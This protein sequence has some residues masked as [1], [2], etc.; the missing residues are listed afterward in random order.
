VIVGAGIAGVS[1]A[2]HLAVRRG[3]QRVVVCDPRQPLSLT[4]DKSTECYRNWWPQPAMTALMNRSIDL[5][6]E[7]ECPLSSRG[8]VYFTADHLDTFEQRARSVARAGAG[9]LRTHGLLSQTPPC[10]AAREWHR[11]ESGADLVTDPD[12]ISRLWPAVARRV[13][14]ALHVRRAGWLD[15]QQLGARLLDEAR[16]AGVGLLRRAVIRIETDRHGITGVE[17]D[18]GERIETPRVVV[19]AGPH[20]NTVVGLLGESVPVQAELHLKVA[21]KDHLGVVPRS[22]PLL[23]WDDP[24]RLAWGD[25]E[26]EALADLDPGLLGVL[27]GGAHLRP[28]GG[29]DSPWVLGL[30]E[31]RKRAMEPVFPIPTDSMYPEV[32]LRGLSTMIPALSPYLERL[33]QSVVDGGYYMKTP[34]N[35]PIIGPLRTPG[36]Y[37]IGALSGFGIMASQ[38]AAELVALHMA[39]SS[40]PGYADAFRLERF[41]DPSY[42]ASANDTGQ[43]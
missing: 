17:L 15:A 3:V 11:V 26:H 43:L 27:G 39:G 12:L 34:E 42:L 16:S 19:A 29:Q 8:Y 40:L 25:E 1:V 21:F 18:D 7:L 9:P 32:V 33:P 30:W 5:L 38:S 4:S 13:V 37:V 31:Y 35:L 23:I 36:A 6:E 28:E 24:Q 14:G 2:Y 22:S 10:D 20:V 41:D